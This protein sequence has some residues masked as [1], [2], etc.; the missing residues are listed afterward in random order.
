LGLLDFRPGVD[1]LAGAGSGGTLA[2]DG[3][4]CGS[5][6]AF[7]GV[8]GTFVFWGKGLVA[9]ADPETRSLL[10]FYSGMALTLS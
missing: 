10:D 7:F 8:E 3:C 6:E 9:G 2:G 1:L 5:D 4:A